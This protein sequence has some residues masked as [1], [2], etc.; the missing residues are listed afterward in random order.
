VRDSVATILVVDDERL[1]RRLL[2][3]LLRPEGYRTRTAGSAEEALA[4]VAGH[5]P[6][7]IL[8]DIMMPGMNG[9]EL[10]AIL[11]AD[12]A[13]SQIPIIMISALN[14]RGARLA[15]LNAGAEDFLSKPVDKAELWVRVRNLLRLKAF[16]DLQRDYGRILAEQ[17]RL[18]TV[19]LQRFRSAMDVT[20]DAI[21]LIDRASMRFV[22]FNETACNMFGFTREELFALGPAGLG[23]TT[24]TVL[25]AVYDRLIANDDDDAVL[26]T[27][28]RCKDGVQMQVE[29]HRQA[30]RF[31]A[32]WLIVA[33]VRDIE[34][35][36]DAE[37]RMHY[38]AHYDALTGLP[39]RTLFYETLARTLDY[40][41]RSEGSVAVLCIDI[42]HFKNVNDTLG[43]A[44]GDELLQQF[45]NRLLD[46]I[47][48]RDT[49][50]RLGGDEFALSMMMQDGSDG[51]AAVAKKIRDAMQVPFE[52]KGHLVSI[53]AS[54]G[55]TVFPDDAQD[56]ET[57]MKHADTAMYRA[58][59]AGRD[60]FRYFTAQMN[61]EVMAHLELQT[62]LRKAVEAGEF[63]LHY[64]PKVQINTGRVAGVEALLRWERPG[65]GLVSPKDFIPA[66]EAS[67]LIVRVGSWVIATACRQIAQ[68]RASAIGPMAISVNVSG[69]Q[70]IEGDLNACVAKALADN[71]VSGDLLELEL[72][73]SSLMENSERTIASLLGLKALGV[74]IS[75]DDFGTGYSSLA[76]LRRFP[77][78][79][80]KID[81]AFIRDVTTNPDDAAIVVAIIRMAQSLKLSV[82][83]EGVESAAQLAYLRR[84]HCDYMQGYL[85]SRPLPL[86][87]LEL[88]LGSGQPMAVDDADIQASGKTVLLV[89][90]DAEVLGALARLLSP[91]GY[92]ILSAQ[93]GARAFE[94]LALH[95]VQ[96]ILCDQ[97]LTHETG[98]ALLNHL[99]DLCP[100]SFRIAL[101]DRADFGSA[102]G[103]VN[104]GAISRF[105]AK[106]WNEPILRGDIREA[107]RNYGAAGLP[108]PSGHAME[109]DRRGLA[110][111]PVSAPATPVLPSARLAH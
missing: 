70:F 66:L 15:S 25:A 51:A 17:V 98:G 31:D 61:V 37:K 63:V 92:R 44:L 86:A 99:R 101:S 111:T 22:E 82:I 110:E 46:C 58:K 93:S 45:S 36:K 102:I 19:E 29:V 23:G 5:A 80:L 57:L 74:R 12:P 1:N 79:A 67:G 30:R 14:D 104:S 43:H 6:D 21:L 41:K 68:W 28:I 85:F 76:Y 91:D 52:L 89:D 42:D 64:Q 18:R 72:T 47:R 60:A 24:D 32:A 50:G 103:L 56:P 108:S 39:N 109:R 100:E 26:E 40:S 97:H 8:L 54:I 94:L 7:L 107:F 9:Y 35:R 59:Q 49:A 71:N 83:A 16:A 78:D 10:A 90:G 106:P 95:Q 81:I 13:T 38:L 53:T 96:V 62:A 87:E 48:V 20:R 105:H 27:R 55:I 77:I 73:E 4:D 3:A 65:H 69:R 11:K 84:H 75:I 88:L 34:Q 2:E 33:V